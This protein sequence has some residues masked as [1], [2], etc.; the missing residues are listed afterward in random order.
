MPT[1]NLNRNALFILIKKLNAFL[2]GNITEGITLK[3]ALIIQN[4]KL[5]LIT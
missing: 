3:L 1:L 4:L 5:T 2:N